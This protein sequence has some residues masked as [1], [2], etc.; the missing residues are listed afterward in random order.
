MRNWDYRY[1]WLRDATFTLYAL[2]I[3]GYQDEA[4]AW[5]EWLRRAVAGEPSK[6]QI[7][8]G[9]AGERRLDEYEIPW[10][11]GFADSGPVRVGNGAYTQRQMDIYGEVMDT[12]HCARTYGL[13]TDG[14]TWRIQRGLL[15]FLEGHWR[16]SGAGLW[17]QRSGE[18]HY[19]YSKVMAW[20]AADRAVKAVERFGLRGPAERWRALRKAI[21]EDVCAR[22]FDPTHNAFVQSYGGKTLDASLLLIPL[23]GF[24]PPDDPRVIGTANAIEREL[25]VDGF[26][27]RYTADEGADGLPPG[28][29]AF[30]ACSFWLADNLALM[31]RR[32]DAQRLFERVL[33]VAND[34]GLLAE[35]YDPRARRQ[36][37]NFPQAFSHVGVINTARN[38]AGAGGPA[39]HRAATGG[40]SETSR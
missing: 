27:R 16:E 34:V 25:T 1:C 20:V 6:M 15:D 35:E 19:T 22:G 3:T 8:Y 31:G 7:M 14:D 40:R 18:Q 36:L 30:L 23:V 33:G 39:H 11:S 32:D 17:E 38:L 10:L 13:N 12:F 9:L 21:H 29:G 5:G 26:V 37:G 4:R 28:E 2:L 24:L